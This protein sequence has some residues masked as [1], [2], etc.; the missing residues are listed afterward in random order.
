MNNWYR[1]KVTD[2]IW[3]KSLSDHIFIWI[4]IFDKVKEFNMFAD[5]PHN[6]TK[7]QKEI[8]DREN[9]HWKHFFRER[10]KDN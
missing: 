10:S 5:Y 1:N 3:W 8:F 6:L 4:F 9:P 2:K 7:E